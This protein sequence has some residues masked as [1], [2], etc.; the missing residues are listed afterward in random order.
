MVGAQLRL[1]PRQT[2][3]RG[4]AVVGDSSGYSDSSILIITHTIRHFRAVFAKLPLLRNF[5]V[6][7][8]RRD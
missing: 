5:H 7:Y 3:Q 6:V 4:Q 8:R 2:V 1:V